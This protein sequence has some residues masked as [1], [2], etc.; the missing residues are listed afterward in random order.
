MSQAAA[1]ALVLEANDLFRAERFSDAAQRFERAVTVFP[2]HAAG[3]KG[4]GHSL[5][6]LGK[7]LEAA[8]AFDRAIGLKPDS[9]TAL[10]GGA[11]AHAEL[12][13]KVIAQ[14]YL[15]RALGLQPTWIAMARGVETL[16]PLLQ[17]SNRA[18]DVMR[19]AFGAFSTKTFRH[20]NNDTTID[21]GRLPHAPAFGQFTYLTV[22]LADTPW[23][24]PERPRVELVMAST[25]D[26][27]VCSTILANLAFHLTASR[28]FPEPGTVV[29]DVVA[30]L[31]A[32]DLS[33]R[34]PHVLVQSPR[35][36]N[37]A[38]PLDEGPPVITVAQVVPISDAE[39]H[40]WRAMG[41]VRL[42]REMQTVDVA[43]LKRR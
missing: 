14:N 35:A 29:R 2:Q 32:G 42:D 20:T 3:W 27:E 5:L 16:A 39:Y 25:V 12:D 26:L 7:S 8:R 22:G 33:E 38:L 31:E 36:W 18:G 4:L 10:W 19:R 34:L 6:C 37:L 9:A 41:A 17:V 30:T 24:E 28:F 23:N 1:D 15:R 11:L 43:D 40:R 13:N 21:V